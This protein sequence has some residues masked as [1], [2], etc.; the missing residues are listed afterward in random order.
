MTRMIISAFSG[1]INR[2]KDAKSG[3]ELLAKDLHGF[4][5]SFAHFICVFGCK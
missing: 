5:N 1:E 3:D 2:A 4:L